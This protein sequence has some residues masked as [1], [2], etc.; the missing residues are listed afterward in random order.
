MFRRTSR[1]NGVPTSL[2]AGAHRYDDVTLHRRLARLLQ[3]GDV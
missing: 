1:L 2:Q 3:G